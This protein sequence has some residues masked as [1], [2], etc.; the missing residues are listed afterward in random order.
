MEESVVSSVNQFIVFKLGDAEYG[1]NIQDIST[2]EQVMPTTRV[3]KTPDYLK[4][5]INLRGDVIPVIDMRKRFNLPPAEETEDTR[6]IIVKAGEVTAGLIVD[7]VSEVLR[8]D[9]S[10][11]ENVANFTNELHAEYITGAGKVGDRIVTLL[12]TEKIVTL[13]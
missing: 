2:I 9:G 12:D 11:I 4:G 13:E 10:S 1:M 3:P 5:V 6:I 7:S 8:L